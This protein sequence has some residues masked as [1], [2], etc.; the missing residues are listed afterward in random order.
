MPST[1]PYDP[2]L[3]LG[4]IVS[5]E[6]LANIIQIS[7]LQ[8]PAD[9]AEY[10]LNSL[11]SLKRSV[12][13][14]IQETMGMGIEPGE[15]I[16]ESEQI[17][18]Q[19]E[20]AAADYGKAK[21]TAEKAIQPLRAKMNAVNESVESPID[22]VR[23]QLKTLPISSDSLQMNVQYFAFDQNSQS[24]QSHAATVAS[25]VS[26]SLSYF[27]ESQAS[28]GSASAQM[29]M[30]SQHSR[31]TIAGTLVITITCTHKNAQV[32]APY[33]LDVDK[34]VRT[35]NALYPD[36]MIKTNDPGSIAKIEANAD[37]KNDKSFS[38][39]SGATYGSS[40]VG[41]V[42][43]LNNTD[44]ESSQSMESIAESM[45]ETFQI[46][47]WFA[48]GTG[49]FGVASTFSNSAKNLLS[50]QNVTSHATL[51]TMGI[52][53]SIKSNQVQMAVKQFS[54]F[55]PQKSMESLAALQNATA[56]ENNTISSSAQSAITGQ[57]MIELKNATI[58]STLSGVSDIDDGQNKVI[59]T[60]SMMT[61]MEDYINRCVDG[62][63]NVG[64]PINYYLKE[65]TQSEIA[66]A[67]M[68]KY[69]PNKYNQAG[70]ADD[71]S[72][73]SGSGSGDAGSGS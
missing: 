57:Q 73:A 60:N 10:E 27:G 14:T 40:F 45:Q 33:V 15:L 20:Q 43:I 55:D 1:I 32:F 8:A 67:W 59:D 39:L 54:D 51:I 24:S 72:S 22:Y 2:S 23:S 9:A 62:G 48:S 58:S 37:T 49:K 70:S 68:A 31:H 5:Q 56:G 26:E 44:S 53:P 35:W 52:I 69:F 30:N 4:N 25:F 13:M 12:D 16:L 38:I 3:V 41:M 17:G 11:I 46:G 63:N 7:Q 36:N 6:K 18:V 66:R 61:A 65:I 34:A 71:S 29:Q 47:G 28:Q 50:T 64:V 42:H 19:I 21:V